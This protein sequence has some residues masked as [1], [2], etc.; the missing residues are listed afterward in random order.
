VKIKVCHNVP[1]HMFSE[2]Y[3]YMQDVLYFT[4]TGNFYFCLLLPRREIYF[5]G[6]L[7][8]FTINLI[9]YLF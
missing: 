7:M 6:L 9:K 5:L 8:S 2:I 4:Y 1:Y 3:I